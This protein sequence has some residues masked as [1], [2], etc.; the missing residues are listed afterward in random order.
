MIASSLTKARTKCDPDNLVPPAT[1]KTGDLL[2]KDHTVGTFEPFYTRDFHII[3]VKGSQVELI[4][5]K[6]GKICMAHITKVKYILPVDRIIFQV[7]DQSFGHKI[8]LYE[9]WSSCRSQFVFSN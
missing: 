6:D 4:S 1:L 7:S 5:T 3:S 8:T 2:L 9:P